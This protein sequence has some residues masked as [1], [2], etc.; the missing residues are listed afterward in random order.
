[1]L[2]RFLTPDVFTVATCLWELM[3]YRAVGLATNF[4]V[5]AHIGLREFEVIAVV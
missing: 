4:T 2:T 1:M 3:G 5:K